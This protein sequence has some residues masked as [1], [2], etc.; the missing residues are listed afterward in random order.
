MVSPPLEDTDLT[1]SP[2]GR[3]SWTSGAEPLLLRL[4]RVRD[5]PVSCFFRGESPP[6]D[7]HSGPTSDET[8]VNIF[9]VPKTPGLDARPLS[10]AATFEG[11]FS[12]SFWHVAHFSERSFFEEIRLLHFPHILNRRDLRDLSVA[13]FVSV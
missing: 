5:T 2:L 1:Q 13:C 6:K 9:C 4:F 10:G 7:A 12:L 8:P 11:R 3:P